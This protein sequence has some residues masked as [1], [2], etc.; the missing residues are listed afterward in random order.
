MFCVDC[1]FCCLI[2]SCEKICEMS[3]EPRRASPWFREGPIAFYLT[4][5]PDQFASV[6]IVGFRSITAKLA[7]YT[8]YPGSRK[9]ALNTINFTHTPIFQGTR[10]TL[11]IFIF[12]ILFI[13]LFSDISYTTETKYCSSLFRVLWRDLNIY[14][15]FFI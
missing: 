9:K 10:R 3:R 11:D 2:P 14:F 6:C 7:L 12:L 15:A 1:F 5:N 8:H 13:F 4:S